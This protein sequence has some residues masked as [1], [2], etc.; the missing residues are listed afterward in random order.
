VLA[1]PEPALHQQKRWQRT[2]DQQQ[3][4]EMIVKKSAVDPGFEHPPV[5]SIEG[6]A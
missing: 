4:V 2:G 5:E 6:T 1:Q 3:V